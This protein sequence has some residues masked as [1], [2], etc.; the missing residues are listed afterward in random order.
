VLVA[1]LLA[2]L[3]LFDPLLD[4]GDILVAVRPLLIGDVIGIA[5]ITPLVLRLVSHERLR[6]G[7]NARTIAPELCLY[8]A[9]VIGV[10]WIVVGASE[11]QGF[12][13]FYLLFLPLV[14][15]AVR[16]GLD[17]ACVGLAVTQLGLVGLLHGYGYDA[18]A[19]TEFQTLMLV[20][21]ATG[22]TV[23]VV[24]SERQHAFETVREV[25]AALKAK[26]EEAA[27]AAR[28]SL[29][30]GTAAA[31]A[32]EIN[33]PMTA[34]RALAR[35]VQEILRS[36][37][38]DFARADNNLTRLIAQI[39]H[40]GDVVRR[41]REF[42]R[43]GRPQASAF[44][45][46]DLLE[47]VLTL[48]RPELAARGIRIEREADAALPPIFGDRVQ[49]QQVVHNLVRN[50]AESI[51]GSRAP[52]GRIRVV[53]QRLDEPARVEIGVID[54]GP[55]V[56]SD[57]ASRLFEPLIS[58]K[59]DGLGLGLSICVSIVEAHHGR[60]WLQSGAPGAT[61]FRFSVPLDAG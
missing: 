54:D 50:A 44:D 61:E 46:G 27:R 35:S 57:V 2:L 17:G 43:R 25:E 20:L 26:Q 58:S 10:L 16:Y 55:G 14:A 37:S 11:A 18:A 45:V 9:V 60:I 51:A 21:S 47:D 12:R 56:G 5:V 40:A 48:A 36:P 13:L 15:A 32:H 22:L 3:L 24:V 19:F 31:L 39:D 4:L 34:A 30:G 6:P 38:A 33:Q 28:V 59:D 23:G 7:R 29:V 52:E 49:L 8:V 42:L 41:I 53:A 1:L